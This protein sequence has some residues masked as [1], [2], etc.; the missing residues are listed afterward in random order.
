[1]TD[2]D[3]AVLALLAAQPLTERA[4]ADGLM[5]QGYFASYDQAAPLVRS[6]AR[7]VNQRKV[8]QEAT[9]IY[10]LRKRHFSAPPITRDIQAEAEG[11]AGKETR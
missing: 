9:G 11:V 5:R 6:L 3:Y 10:C 2:I 1:M 7:L 8:L 4:L